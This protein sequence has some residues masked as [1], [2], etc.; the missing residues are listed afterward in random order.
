MTASPALRR[1][2]EWTRTAPVGSEFAYHYDELDQ[3][4]R[5][6][7]EHARK[8]S[9]A[10]LAFLFQKRLVDGGFAYIA[11][12]TEVKAHTVLDKVSRR[13][14]T[15]ASTAYKGE[16]GLLPAGRPSKAEKQ[17]ISVGE[18]PIPCTLGAGW[19]LPERA[20]VED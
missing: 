19:N 8:L 9:D 1:F 5:A 14:P 17:R 20:L 4:E 2:R 7:F 13:I 18:T 10:G 15:V 3:R 12:R 11:R 16:M 6:V